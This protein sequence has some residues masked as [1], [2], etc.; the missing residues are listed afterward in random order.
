MRS[1]FFF[2][3]LLAVAGPALLWGQ[4]NAP[5]QQDDT[6]TLHVNVKL[7]SVFTNVTDA[8]GAIV[9][10]LT[11]EDFAI[12][13]DGRPQKISVFERQSELPLNL[14]LAIDTSGSVHK[15]MPLEQEAAHKFAHALLRQQDQMSLLEFSNDVRQV[16][17]FTNQPA[18]IDRGL[19]TLRGGQA[20]ALYDAIFLASDTLAKLSQG[21]KSTRKILVLVSDGGDTADTVTYADAL[22]HA[23]R[24]EVMVYSIIDV[25]IAASAGRDTGGEH[26]MITLAEQTGGKYFYAESGGLDAAFAKVSEDLRTQYLLGYYPAHQEPGVNFHR[27]HVTVPRAAAEAFDIRYRTGYYAD[28][29]PSS[30]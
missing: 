30:D 17:G 5:E 27:I 9:G 2:V 25:P 26:A 20:T 15:D 4:S 6:F 29:H 7:V 16:V 21:S 8:N 13:E 24:G 18:K 1:R 28:S 10:G 11:K 19:S 23:L 22:E 12:T 14:V 3:T